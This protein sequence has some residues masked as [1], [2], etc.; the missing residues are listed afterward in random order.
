MKITL[1]TTKPITYFF[2]HFHC[3]HD[4]WKRKENHTQE[5]NTGRSCQITSSR[6][7]TVSSY[8]S[9]SSPHL[10]LSGIANE[11]SVWRTSSI[12]I[13]SK[14]SD[15]RAIGHKQRMTSSSTIGQSF[16]LFY[17]NADFCRF[18]K[19]KTT[20]HFQ[21]FPLFPPF[22]LFTLRA[23]TISLIHPLKFCFFGFKK[24][25]KISISLK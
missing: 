22:P 24:S 13:S 14:N 11:N 1:H 7:T 15:R 17:V 21:F 4:C 20:I 18:F 8:N 16:N 10:S 2:F 5:E 19:A 12:P 9:V 6:L 23:A 25:P 3:R